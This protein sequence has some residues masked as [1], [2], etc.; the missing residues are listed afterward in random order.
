[1][2]VYE[3]ASGREW[4][5]LPPQAAEIWALSWSPDGTRVAAGLTDGGV[6]VWDLEQVPP[7]GG[8]RDPHSVHRRADGRASASAA[9]GGRV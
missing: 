7:A 1:M 4:A 8:V 9:L 5:V 3:L 2:I 6:V